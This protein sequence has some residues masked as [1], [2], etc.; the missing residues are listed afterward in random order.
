MRSFLRYVLVLSPLL[1]AIAWGASI[2]LEHLQERWIERDL[3]R[4]SS[5]VFSS[6]ED[7]LS[8][9]LSQEKQ[10]AAKKLL[11]RISADE[12]LYGVLVCPPAVSGS[13]GSTLAP[14]RSDSVSVSINCENSELTEGQTL[15]MPDLSLYVWRFTVAAGE[16]GQA[17]V[18]IY[19][20]ASLWHARTKRTRLYLFGLFIGTALAVIAASTLVARWT[21]TGP[22]RD[23]AVFLREAVRFGNTKPRLQNLMKSEFS[24]L[25]KDLMRLTNDYQKLRQV[26]RNQYSGGIWTAERLKAFANEAFSTLPL[27]VISNREPLIHQAKG[28][29]TIHTLRPASGLVTGV[30]PLLKAC[31]G[32]WIAHGSG[33][34]DRDTVDS[35]DCIGV[36][37][38]KPE[39]T[40]RR[41]WIDKDVEAGYYYGFSNEGL[42]PLCHIAHQRPR[43]D[44]KDWDS[45]RA[46]NEQFAKTFYEQLK[47][48]P[49]VVLI[50]DYHFS[51]LPRLIRNLSPDSLILLFWHIPWPNPEAFGIC[52]W[53]REIL[54]GMLGADVLGFHTQFH[55]NNFIDTVDRVVE[56]RID[57]EQLTVSLR[58]H[59][60]RI[61][62][63]PISIACDDT[64]T[65]RTPS[66]RA[67][68]NLPEDTILGLGV[69]RVDYTKGI[70]ERFHGIRRF[71]EQRPDLARRFAFVQIG[72]PSRTTIPAYQRLNE[73]VV[74]LAEQIN[75]ECRRT[76]GRDLIVMKLEHH[77]PE[78]LR[79]YYE[80][81]DICLVSALH[82]GMNLVAKEFVSA[83]T[84]DD[85]VL[86]LSQFTGASRELR[87][88]LIINPY[89]PD[90]IASKLVAACQMPMSEQ[91]DRMRLMRR[92]VLENNVFKWAYSQLV[93]LND[94]REMRS[95]G[96]E[97]M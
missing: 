76:L 4:R 97:A 36:P 30:E 13:R 62:P 15:Q 5:L 19:N 35:H 6:I 29:G 56:S 68:L 31:N 38:E 61:R 11:N 74:F 12:L 14:V 28:G 87:E 63:F 85:G 34:A 48:K 39:Y 3:A 10:V 84:K 16:G 75:G 69:D 20:D 47:G 65:H 1:L 64:G 51:L 33:S 70:A 67:A 91:K 86:I 77:N 66:I 60:C 24:P 88:A 23:V 89:G 80:Q 42:W 53:R 41:V 96:R 26:A 50:Q 52:P 43:F 71:A 73:E 40:L 2:V 27:C 81:S 49:A 94:V 37:P 83:R 22:L 57:R 54:E 92:T 78:E 82:D 55:C 25:V 44:G 79:P 90:D 17:T 46:V 59:E 18:Y 8:E 9:L 7:N 93:E 45:Y 72:A 32:T 21:I 95:L 58:G